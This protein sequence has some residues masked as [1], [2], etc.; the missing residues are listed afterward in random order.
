MRSL[1][2]HAQAMPPMRSV[3][4]FGAAVILVIVGLLG[5]H[6][7][8]AT[9]GGH[10]PAASGQHQRSALQKD[11]SLN[12]SAGAVAHSSLPGNVPAVTENVDPGSHDG[13]MLACVLALLTGMLLL[14]APFLIR[15]SFPLMC[16]R[17]VHVP[18]TATSIRPH[19][20]SLIFLSISRT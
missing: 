16:R 17:V 15:S 20:P 14:A 5:M 4:L 18:L 6:T 1:A 13:W 2:G 11:S 7:F 3:L 9:P 19:P 12:H 8:S 10:G